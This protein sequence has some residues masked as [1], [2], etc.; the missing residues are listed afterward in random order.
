MHLVKYYQ[1]HNQKENLI[2]I[3]IN[4]LSKG[5]G[6]SYE[7]YKFL[8]NQ[9]DKGEWDKIKEE[10]I[11]IKVTQIISAQVNGEKVLTLELLIRNF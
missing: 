5:N 7:Y 11:I 8:K 3:L 9:Y 1:K 10:I 2:E 4:T 6:S